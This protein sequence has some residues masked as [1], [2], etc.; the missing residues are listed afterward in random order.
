MKNQ[1]SEISDKNNARELID[2]L[3]KVIY[4]VNL[5]IE[6]VKSLEE[7]KKLADRE[8]FEVR[9]DTVDLKSDDLEIKKNLNLLNQEAKGV[10]HEII[11]LSER[12][13]RLENKT[14][15]L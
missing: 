13:A 15:S 10:N 1:D 2:T 14:K 12:V 6:K 8:I 5:L 3:N 11:K 4:D 7:F 9:A